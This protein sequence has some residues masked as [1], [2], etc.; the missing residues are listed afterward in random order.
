[1]SEF[2]IRF[3]AG[4]LDSLRDHWL[5]LGAMLPENFQNIG[6]AIE[7]AAT[8]ASL[9]YGDYLLGGEIP[10]H[11]RLNRPAI[12]AGNRIC[13]SVNQMLWMIGHD[14]DKARLIEV[15][16]PE[17]DMKLGIA[18]SK[19]ARRSA[20][21][22][23]LYLIIPFRHGSSGNSKGTRGLN[24]MP[25]AVYKL[26][27]MLEFSRVTGM[28]PRLSATGHIVPQ[29]IYGW[30]GRLP[31]GLAPK[32]K[33]QHKGDIYAGMVRFKDD[34]SKNRSGAYIT[35][36]TMSQ[37]SP[38][39]SWIRPAQPGLYPLETAMRVAWDSSQDSLDAALEA[40]VLAF[41]EAVRS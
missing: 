12:L 17:T 38:A 33:P 36:R 27:K 8:L 23:A 20:K 29:R 30:G 13:R 40:D 31:A 25:T 15:G 3:P 26:A 35:F 22:G 9:T 19:K 34:A 18:N 4:I 37:N 28:G 5:A 2:S 10:G 41:L 1:M 39:R 24:T 6:N 32:M 14:D 11:G 16:T 7:D 21:T